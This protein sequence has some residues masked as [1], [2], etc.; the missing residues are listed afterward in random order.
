MFATKLNNI[1]GTEVST[2]V[3]NSQ[4]HSK[5]WKGQLIEPSTEIT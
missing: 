2:I 3:Y 1:S 5:E 4:L